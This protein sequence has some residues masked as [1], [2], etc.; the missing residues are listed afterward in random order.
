MND[1]ESRGVTEPDIMNHY[2]KIQLDG[3][4]IINSAVFGMVVVMGSY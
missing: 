3:E 4:N 2:S 1:F